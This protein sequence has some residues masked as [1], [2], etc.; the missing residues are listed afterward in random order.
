MESKNVNKKISHTESQT[1]QLEFSDMCL[2]YQEF[3]DDLKNLDVSVLTP[4]ESMNMLYKLVKKA[5]QI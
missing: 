5:N 3:V 4:I 1:A 2:P